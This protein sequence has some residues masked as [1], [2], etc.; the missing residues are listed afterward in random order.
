MNS[1]EK[2]ADKEADSSNFKDE[3]GYLG[4]DLLPRAKRVRSIDQ[5]NDQQN[6][7]QKEQDLNKLRRP[8]KFEDEYGLI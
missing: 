5:Q 8:N 6:D 2:K 1:V 7:Q 3:I 4:S